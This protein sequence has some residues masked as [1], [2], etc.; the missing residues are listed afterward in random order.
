[1]SVTR[2][3]LPHTRTGQLE[4]AQSWVSYITQ[5][6]AT[7]WGIPTTVMTQLENLVENA[8]ETLN[9]VASFDRTPAQNERI[10]SAFGQLVDQMRDI[11]R[12]YFFV[13][14]LTSADLFEIGLKPPDT[15]PTPVGTPTSVVQAEISYP[16]K[17]ALN[18]RIQAMPGSTY[19]DRA[20]YGFRIYYGVLPQVPVSEELMIE[21][22]Y[23]RREPQRPEELTQSHFT[24]RKRDVLE[25]SYDNSGMKCYIC[26]RYENGKGDKGPWGP[27]VSA[28][29]P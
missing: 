5:T 24:R 3:W 15:T 27:I 13:P 21:R 19:D 12:R 17:N 25:F 14:P 20:D 22:Q 9:S 1:M 6:K 29:V 7:A 23:L 26:I 4:M 10:R 11:K 2:D 16:H 28:V 18:V 8:N